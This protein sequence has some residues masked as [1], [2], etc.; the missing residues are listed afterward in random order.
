MSSK[1]S[2]WEFESRFRTKVRHAV[3]VA[4]ETGRPPEL[5]PLPSER[6][7]ATRLLLRG[8]I[9]PGDLERWVT[10]EVARG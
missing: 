8:Q 2:R 5:K 10:E 7:N 3:K 4:R 6:A 9:K 1:L